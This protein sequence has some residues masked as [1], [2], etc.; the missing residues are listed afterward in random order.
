LTAHL[1]HNLYYLKLG[2]I[3][4]SVIGYWSLFRLCQLKNRELVACCSILQRRSKHC[5]AMASAGKT[6]SPQFTNAQTI[7]R[8][9]CQWGMMHDNQKMFIPHLAIVSDFFRS[10]FV[11]P[12]IM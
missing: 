11:N 3:N 1:E 10:A 5:C 2:K 4:P 9:F 6:V 12:S 7:Y 8:G